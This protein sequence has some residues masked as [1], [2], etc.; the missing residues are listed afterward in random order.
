MHKKIRILKTKS[1]T[2]SP[3]IPPKD[4]IKSNMTKTSN[5]KDKNISNKD[6]TV[7]NKSNKSENK[8]LDLPPLNLKKALKNPNLAPKLSKI[9]KQSNP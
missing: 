4:K 6:S 2:L 7:E 3:P 1:K 8:N 5:L 9:L